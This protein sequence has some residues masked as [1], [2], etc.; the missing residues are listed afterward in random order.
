MYDWPE[1]HD[2]VDA[3]WSAIA[4]CLRAAGIDAPTTL[5][6]YDGGATL[7]DLWTDPDLLVA[8]TCGLPVVDFLRGRIEVLGSLDHGV[9]GCAPGDYRSVLVCRADDPA[10]SLEGFRGRRAI[11]NSYES[12]SGYG[13]LVTTVAPLAVDGRFF[14]ELVDSGTHRFSLRAVADGRADLAAIDVVSWRLGLAHEPAVDDLRIVAWTEPTPGLP[15]VTGWAQAGLWETL[16]E[17]ISAAVAD[18]HVAVREPLHLYG[19]RPRPTSDYEVIA[20]R[21]AA[22]ATAGYSP[23][24]ARLESDSAG[25]TPWLP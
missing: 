19:Y 8:Q 25:H 9:E 22:A 11:V 4:D 23:L 24:P 2:A 12:Q 7:D 18:L 17:A 1:V 21:L 15:L 3:L 16:N 20:E 14:D 6:R 5:W 13:A 10:E